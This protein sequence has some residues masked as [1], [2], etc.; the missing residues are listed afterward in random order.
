MSFYL[1]KNFKGNKET[2][3]IDKYKD[4]AYWVGIFL[5]GMMTG[6]LL[7]LRLTF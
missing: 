7:T 2:G 5:I 6:I 1:I 3:F 4:F